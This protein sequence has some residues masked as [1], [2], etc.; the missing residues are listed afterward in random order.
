MATACSPHTPPAVNHAAGQFCALQTF[1]LPGNNK[2]YMQMPFDVT[3]IYLW[4]LYFITDNFCESYFR[5]RSIGING[6]AKS[7]FLLSN[8][9]LQPSDGRAHD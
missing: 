7:R 4:R 3:N 5:R 1:F 9:S 8:Q 2:W 6:E